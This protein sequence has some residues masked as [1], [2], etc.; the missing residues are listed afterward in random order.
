MVYSVVQ[1]E[2]DSY[3]R[4]RMS[5]PMRFTQIVYVCVQNSRA[6]NYEDESSMVQFVSLP[7]RL[8]FSLKGNVH[9]N[10]FLLNY[11]KCT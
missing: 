2:P 10:F 9:R 6:G 7:G 5:T 3:L 4:I 11:D 1:P 8:N